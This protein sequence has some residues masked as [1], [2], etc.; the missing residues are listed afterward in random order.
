MVEADREKFNTQIKHLLSDD[1]R[2]RMST[3][4]QINVRSQLLLTAAALQPAI[5]GSPNK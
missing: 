1:Q 3:P 2:A 4:P 5:P